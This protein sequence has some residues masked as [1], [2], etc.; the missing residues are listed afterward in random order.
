MRYL[1]LFFL[2]LSKV[3]FAQ[4]NFQ[5]GYIILKEKSDTIKGKIDYQNWSV[6]PTSIM[7]KQVEPDSKE[8]NISTL[9]AFGIYEKENYWVKTIDLDET[10]ISGNLQKSPNLLIKHNNT[11]ALLVLLQAK[12]SLLYYQDSSNKDHFFI[13]DLGST[14]ELINHKYMI[15]KDSRTYEIEDKR[16]KNQLDALFGNCTKKISTEALAYNMQELTDKMIE[17]NDCM[18][19]TYTCY[20]RKKE[21]KGFSTIEVMGGIGIENQQHVFL[22][23]LTNN[24][25]TKQIF[26]PSFSIGASYSIHS[27]RDNGNKIARFELYYEN[28]HI[29]SEVYKYSTNTPFLN[30][31]VLYRKKSSI[32]HLLY[33]FG[34]S[35]QIFLGSSINA[36]GNH[37]TAFEI[38]GVHPYILTDL[39]YSYKKWE[40]FLRTKLDFRNNDIMYF[41]G[42]GVG[43]DENAIFN[44]LKFHFMLSYSLNSKKQ[45]R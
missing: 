25:T 14:Q 5:N 3:S 34:L 8:I 26:A 38:L 19:C 11:L 33:G 23:G 6:S 37:I 41:L 36:D 1:L 2:L 15:E 22:S 18:D 42:T 31:N 30:L 45:N 17:F 20:V 9:K 24:V 13:D 12:Y 27:K 7:F 40:F 32:N 44:T 35:N 28:Q 39:G 4:S 29:S 21:D 43:G 16:Y 10:P